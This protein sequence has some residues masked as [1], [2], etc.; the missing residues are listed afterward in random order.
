M[1]DALREA[2]HPH[3]YFQAASSREVQAYQQRCAAP[4]TKRKTRSATGAEA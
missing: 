4:Q 2:R 3:P 1:H